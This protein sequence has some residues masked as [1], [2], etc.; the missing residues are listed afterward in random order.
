[1]AARKEGWGS[2]NNSRK[3]HYF[4]EDGR[5]LCG[6]WLCFVPLWEREQS[7][8]FTEGTC[9]ACHTKRTTELLRA[10]KR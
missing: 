6:G 3:A 2:M 1:M 5:S 8:T 9:K 4:R 10:A 7:D